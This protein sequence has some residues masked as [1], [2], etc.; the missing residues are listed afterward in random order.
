MGGSIIP[1]G[2]QNPLEPAREGCY[3]LHGPNIYNFTEIFEF[4][5]RNNV[6]KLVTSEITL[7]QELISNFKNIKNNDKLKSIMK[8][9]SQ[10]ILLDHINYLNSFIK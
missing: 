8:E 2:G 4:L 9:Y 7:S 1:H 3:L 5:T 10:K 6:S